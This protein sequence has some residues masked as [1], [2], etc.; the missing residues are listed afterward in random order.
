MI[1]TLEEMGERVT[2]VELSETTILPNSS[3][4]VTENGYAIKFP[5]T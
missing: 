5:L 1:V 2:H 4:S 3:I